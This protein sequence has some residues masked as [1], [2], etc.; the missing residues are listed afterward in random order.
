MPNP[1]V[2]E[3]SWNDAIRTGV[4]FIDIQHRQLID[5]I[6]DL[7]TAINDDCTEQELPIL[8]SFLEN[9]ADYHF[10]Q[11][12]ECAASYQCPNAQTNKQAHERFR[13]IL[14]DLHHQ[15]QS[16]GPTVQTATHMHNVL[17]DW[18]VTHIMRIDKHIGE[19]VLAGE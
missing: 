2:K 14:R 13:E 3:I 17:S 16:A 15:V 5:A 18:L 10:N 4:P 11:E 7:A 1:I 6:N 12:E 9:Y 19:C 8:V